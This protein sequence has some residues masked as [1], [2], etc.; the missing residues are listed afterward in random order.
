MPMD[1]NCFFHSIA[2]GLNLKD[3][4]SHLNLRALVVNELC[5]HKQ[6]YVDFL[7]ETESWERFIQALSRPGTWAGEIAI[8][9]VVNCL[10]ITIII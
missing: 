2:Y 6:D 5:N 3:P 8:R 7:P 4:K 10:M 1:G 9:A